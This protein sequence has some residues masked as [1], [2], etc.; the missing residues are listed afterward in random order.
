MVLRPEKEVSKRTGTE[1]VELFTIEVNGSTNSV[2]RMG[3][4][5]FM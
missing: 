1:N 3:R 5:K 4:E 2:K